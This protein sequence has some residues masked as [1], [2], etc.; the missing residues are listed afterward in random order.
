MISH[1]FKHNEN[2]RFIIIHI[3]NQPFIQIATGLT[4]KQFDSHYL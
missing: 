2:C 3:G 1:F 4:V